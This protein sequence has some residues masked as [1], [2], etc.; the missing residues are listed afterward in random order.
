LRPLPLRLGTP[1]QF[2]ACRQ[3]LRAVGYTEEALLARYDLKALSD[4]RSRRT[5][6]ESI[7]D[8]LELLTQ[9]FVDGAHVTRSQIAFFLPNGALEALAALGLV[10]ANAINRELWAAPV[11]LYPRSGLFLIS[12]RPKAL[13]T[14]QVQEVDDIVFSALTDNTERF[15]ELLPDEPCDSFL[16]LGTG[17]GV[18]ALIAAGLARHVW[19]VD[20]TE[21][22]AR[23]AEFN[24]RLNG[25][26]NVTVL[27]GDLFA[28]VTDLRFDRI[29]IHPPYVPA[30]QQAL[31][32]Q[33][34]GLDGQDI[35]RRA[36]SQLPR[37]LSP[38]GRFYCLTVGFDSDDAP[39]EHTVRRWLEPDDGGFDVAFAPR[40]SISV[41]FM[42]QGVAIKSSNGMRD[43][44][45]LEEAFER[46]KIREFVYGDI[47]IQRHAAPRSGFTVRR[48]RTSG[49]GRAAIDWLLRWETELASQGPE[50]LLGAR[51]QASPHVEFLV[52]HS[53]ADGELAP[54]AYRLQTNHPFSMEAK[55]TPWMGLF[56]ARCDGTA[57]G[58]EHYVFLKEQKAFPDSVS[59]VDFARLLGQLASGGFIIIPGYEPLR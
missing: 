30:L 4:L 39:F 44:T 18:A 49:S 43:A 22:A 21:R 19:A 9:L 56:V 51:P 1:E 42:A 31:I 35:T 5:R 8:A 26:T 17:T 37:H 28:P 23:I 10:R 3:P 46:L 40:Y 47:I 16:D 27:Q 29:V 14:E 7:E 11:M 12:D 20:V 32:Y 59:P 50:W 25:V 2:A 48:Q 24:R 52:T 54:T 15:L 55:A 53:M 34:A 36:V 38:G 45:R 57:T 41:R 6:A 33:D 13:D 58:R